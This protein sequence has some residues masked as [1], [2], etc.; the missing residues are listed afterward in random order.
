M[1]TEGRQSEGGPGIRRGNPFAF[2][3]PMA[4]R[5]GYIPFRIYIYAA[6]LLP[7][8]VD[9]GAATAPLTILH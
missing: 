3:G 4:C 6:R 2:T 7:H 9:T 8:S 5:W 1:I